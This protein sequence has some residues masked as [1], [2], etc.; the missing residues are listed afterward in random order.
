[1]TLVLPAYAKLNLT[2][3]VIGRRPDGYHD[4]ESVMQTISLHDLVSVERSDCKVFDVVGPP[5]AG[6]N[7]VL[8]AARELEA[9]IGQSLSF[10]IRL[11]KRIPIGAGLGGGSSDAAAFLRAAIV[12]YGI[13]ISSAE[14][15]EL[16]Q[17]V[18]QD[19]PFFLRGGTALATG[20]GSTVEPLPP[21][22]GSW[23]FALVCP[24]IEVSTKEVYA[25]VDGSSPSAGR[26]GRVAAAL[27]AGRAPDPGAF[28]NDLEATATARYPQLAEAVAPARARM[29]HLTMTGTGGAFFAAF[30]DSRHAAALLDGPPPPRPS[31]KRGGRSLQTP[32]GGGR[33]MPPPR[34]SPKRGGRS[35]QTPEGGGGPPIR[36]YR[37]VP[38]WG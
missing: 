20:L 29:R 38:A 28:G 32:E 18:G 13:K 21:I 35:M 3:D 25:A 12:L 9:H 5:I 33:S 8:K 34:P 17:R 6:E 4:I 30:L 37:P 10:E 11:H 22:P 19:V 15:Q 1:M 24:A 36:L 26:T 14:L 7:L 31:P 16:A 27:K 2:L 23:R